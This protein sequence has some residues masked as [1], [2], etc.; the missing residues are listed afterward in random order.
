[1]Q[2]PSKTVTLRVVILF[3][4]VALAVTATAGFLLNHTLPAELRQFTEAQQSADFEIYEAIGLLSLLAVLSALI[5]GMIGLVWCQRWARI[6]FSA[7]VIVGPVVT[8]VA[9]FTYPDTLVSNAVELGANEAFTLLIGALFAM[10][11][12]WMPEEFKSAKN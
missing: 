1:M 5:V 11:W 6:L 10:T 7:V 8:A 4:F 2:A 3:A 12:L 9:G